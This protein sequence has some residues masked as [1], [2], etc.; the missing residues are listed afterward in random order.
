L[1]TSVDGKCQ[2]HYERDGANRLHYDNGGFVDFR[3]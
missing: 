3:H 1:R 2:E